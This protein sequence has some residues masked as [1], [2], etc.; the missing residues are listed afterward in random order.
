LRPG[1]LIL[2]LSATA[3]T[4]YHAAYNWTPFNRE[5]GGPV[6]SFHV[7]YPT[8][9]PEKKYN[10]LSSIQG[11]VLV[12]GPL[13]EGEEKKTYP[14]VIMI[15]D[16]RSNSV[17]LAWLG[18]RLARKGIVAAA[19]DHAIES[20]REG[21]DQGQLQRDRLVDLFK[22]RDH[23]RDSTE[24]F[25]ADT[26]RLGLF[27]EGEGALT[28]LL[29]IGVRLERPPSNGVAWPDKR[30][31]AVRAVALSSADA[32]RSARP[33]LDPIPV[34]AFRRKSEIDPLIEAF[35]GAHW[36]VELRQ[37]EE[38]AKD[39]RRDTASQVASFF[40]GLL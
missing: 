13:P 3:C 5:Y 9:W 36:S 27:G 1:V 18:E 15:P 12:D 31:F 24:R 17:S 16:R 32:A 10:Y 26:S 30:L 14:V 39:V 40:G 4:S 21:A 19:V 11:T 35:R 25:H 2:A 33:I 7:W 37:A 6:R 34:L 38:G 23:L 28:T 29:A 20:E 22:L 8:D